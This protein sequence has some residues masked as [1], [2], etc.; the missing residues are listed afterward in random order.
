MIFQR[1]FKDFSQ[2]VN[3]QRLGKTFSDFK[4]FQGQYKLCTS[5]C[6][7]MRPCC[8]HRCLT[9]IRLDVPCQKYSQETWPA[10][11]KR[12]ALW[13]PLLRQEGLIQFASCWGMLVRLLKSCIFRTFFQLL[14]SSFP[15]IVLYHPLFVIF[16]CFN[17]IY[18]IRSLS[19][20][21][22]LTHSNLVFIFLVYWLD[23][24]SPLSA[25]ISLF[26]C[27]A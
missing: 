22:C 18:F 25:L 7:S 21:I 15:Y 12:A 6:S 20:S 26:F 24:I 19:C 27:N 3:F 14:C 17:M 23:T 2:F 9:W 4:D 8:T 10:R 16:D 1:F 5:T 11:L 13:E